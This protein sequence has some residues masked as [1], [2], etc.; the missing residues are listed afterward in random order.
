[1]NQTMR[2]K[3]NLFF[4]LFFSVPLSSL[5][6]GQ[7]VCIKVYNKT[8]Y[9]LDSLSFDHFYL[10]LLRKDSTVLISEIEE[11]IMQGELPLH[12]PFG[13]IEGKS[14]QNKML[15]CSTKSKKNKSGY[16]EFDLFIFETNND[17]RL[18]WRKH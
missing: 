5:L 17:Y 3:L 6:L 12:R 7:G 1:M 13:I 16:Y 4:L 18:Y 15:K 2:L 8:G 11:I 14:R 10:G 9:D